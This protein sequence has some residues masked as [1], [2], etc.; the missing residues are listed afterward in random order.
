MGDPPPRPHSGAI[1]NRKTLGLSSTSRSDDG[2]TFLANT[3]FVQNL[4]SAAAAADSDRRL[5]SG[6]RSRS[7][8][9]KLVVACALLAG[10]VACAGVEGADE[11]DDGIAD[12]DDGEDGVGST[13][14]ELQGPGPCA[15][16]AIDRAVKC[17]VNKGARVLSYY[18][19]PANQERVRREN[20][21]TN[22]CTGSAGCVRPTAGC[23]SSPHTACRAVDLVADG[24]PLTRTQ[25]RSCGLAKT[26]A[27]H[28]NH[29]DLVN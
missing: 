14:D 5:A 23:T 11:D 2:G 28:R 13:S 21:C 22:R 18:R 16:K 26:N 25:L 1:S 27:P 19:S 3:P 10:V 6:P 4:D 7:F 29:Y 8:F 12:E 24:A 20:H 15:G 17:A 9:S